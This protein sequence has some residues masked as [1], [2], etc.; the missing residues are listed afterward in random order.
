MDD[1]LVKQFDKYYPNGDC[2]NSYV[3]KITGG[4]S[5]REITYHEPHG[6]GDAHYVDVYYTNG[7]QRRVFRPDTIDFS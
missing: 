6:E 2:E 5:I 7:Y 3:G 1:L 4:I